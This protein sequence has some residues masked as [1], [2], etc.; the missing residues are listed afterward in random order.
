MPENRKQLV[1]KHVNQ[2]STIHSISRTGQVR[3]HPGI[4]YFNGPSS[5][6]YAQVRVSV[7]VKQL[8]HCVMMPI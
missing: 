7:T 6:S 8:F 2:N 1:Y 5:L 4:G 3:H